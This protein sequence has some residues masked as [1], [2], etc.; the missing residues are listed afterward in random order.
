MEEQNN[1]KIN[2]KLWKNIAIIA[3]IFSFVMC[4]LII[5]NYIQLNRHDPVKTEIINALV[6]RLNDNPKDEALRQEIRELDL[7][8][9]KAYFTNQWQIKMGG[10]LLLIGIAIFV[11]AF[12]IIEYFKKINPEIPQES[13]FDILQSNLKA[14]KWIGIAGTVIIVSTVIVAFT[15]QHQLKDKFI[16]KVEN[17]ELEAE[18]KEQGQEEEIQEPRIKSQEEEIIETE[19]PETKNESQEPRA[20]TQEEKEIIAETEKPEISDSKQETKKPETKFP[21]INELKQNFPS[22]RGYDGNGIAFQKDVPLKWDVTTGENLL[23]KTAIP[24]HGYNSPIIWGDKVFLTGAN[25]TTREIYCFDINSG[26]I[27]WTAKADNIEG[28]PEKSPKVTDDTGHAAPTMTTDGRRVYAIFS[29]GDIVALTLDGERVWAKNMGLPEN[30]YGHSSSLITFEDLVIVQY[31]QRN[32]QKV[33]ALNTETGAE[34]WKTSRKVKISW[35]SPVVVNT[36]NR[37]EVILA[38]DPGVQ[39]YDVRTGKELWKQDCIYGEVGPSVAYDNGIVFA[40]N[41][42]ASLVAIKLGDQPKIMWES[43][44]YLS[45]IPSPIAKDNLLYLPTSYGV[46]ACFDVENGNIIWEK[47]FDNGFYGSPILINDNIYII[48][49]RGNTKVFK[50]GKEFN[51]VASNPLGESST[52][53]PAFADGKI[54]IRG[55]KNLYCIGK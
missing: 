5:A 26:K 20:K 40:T 6:E 3:G 28:S 44:D 12:Q 54:L 42:Y 29:N 18:I 17:Q 2:I 8:V 48:D 25:A 4:F 55:D 49:R 33:L 10:Y 53:T 43:Y 30:H 1:N 24:L 27:L 46:I 47:E 19:Q 39:S 34:V 11:I 45:D 38:A 7:L 21:T 50:T 13:T 22:F 16:A 41:E 37:T 32:G 36:G 52:S 31:D 9:R 51:L 14:R 35:A 15:T 23:W